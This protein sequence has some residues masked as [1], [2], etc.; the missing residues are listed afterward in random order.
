MPVVQ[1]ELGIN[2]D[3]HFRDLLASPRIKYSTIAGSIPNGKGF[4]LNKTA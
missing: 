4:Y 1:T 2:R 3:K